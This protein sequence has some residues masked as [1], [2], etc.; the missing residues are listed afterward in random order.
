MAQVVLVVTKSP[1]FC[2]ARFWRL[3]EIDDSGQG[4]AAVCAVAQSSDANTKSAR[5]Y[6][7]WRSSDYTEGE[8][9]AW[10]GQSAMLSITRNW[11]TNKLGNMSRCEGRATWLAEINVEPGKER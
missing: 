9:A 2:R 11:Y 6:D 5:R 1:W 8:M 3:G 10:G 4:E 7:G